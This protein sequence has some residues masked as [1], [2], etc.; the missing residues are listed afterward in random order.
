MTLSQRLNDVR[1]L[2]STAVL[3]LVLTAA[4][5]PNVSA[6]DRLGPAFPANP[7]VWTSDERS[8]A[9]AF[10]QTQINS[11]LT[12]EESAI[13]DGRTALVEALKFPGATELYISQLS[14]LV[15][16]SMGP[17]MDSQNLMVRMNAM[18]ICTYLNHS[19]VSVPIEQGLKD[20]NAGVRYPAAN[21][22]ASLL[23]GDSL[24]GNER[25]EV[26]ILLEELAVKEQDPFV[27]KPLLD[28]LVQTEDNALVLRVLDQRVALHAAQPTVN[29]DA[30]S[31]TLQVIYT[32]IYTETTPSIDVVKELAKVS[33]RYMKLSAQQLL[34]GEISAERNRSHKN[35][36]NVAATALRA[37]REGL[38][39][40]GRAPE[41]P[42]RPLEQ[43]N[44]AR[45]ASIADE[46]I[47][48]L[49]LPPYG[50]SEAALSVKP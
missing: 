47:E 10:V 50:F 46:W 15:A 21:A 7:S 33:S 30:E 18:I 39:A 8:Q 43:D 6:Q 22:M 27:V 20:E 26:L 44:W 9:R 31:N 1:G 4:L 35:I 37:T 34:N 17:L 13:S 12:E 42:G 38:A 19:S 2:G 3:S 41:A 16:A 40:P 24:V 23:T 29:Y 48:V 11:I 5:V 45:V 36:I 28:A 32:R 14:E 25:D 49:K